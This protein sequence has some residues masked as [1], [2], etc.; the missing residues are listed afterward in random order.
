MW[1]KRLKMIYVLYSIIAKWLPESRHLKL[2]K[3]LRLFFA[4][5]IIST[6]RNSN[7]ERGASFTPGISVGERSSIGVNCE[8][9]GNVTIGNDVMMGPDCVIYTQNHAHSRT[10]IPMINQGYENCQPVVIMDDVWLG[11]RVIILPGVTIGRGCIIAA[12]AVVTKSISDFC[13]VGG[14]PAKVISMRKC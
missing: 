10:D 11:R 13:V 7:I 12:G 1:N 4:S 14:V 6:C 2:A 3:K 5:K 9:W 8:L